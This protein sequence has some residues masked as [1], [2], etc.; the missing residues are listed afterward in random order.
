MKRLVILALALPLTACEAQS[1]ESQTVTHTHTV[2]VVAAPA[3]RA[4]TFVSRPK[5]V[6][7]VT[8]SQVDSFVQH[9]LARNGDQG[10]SDCYAWG[11]SWSCDM[12]VTTA[13]VGK[14]LQTWTI[15]VRNW[16]VTALK[17][18]ANQDA[19]TTQTTQAGCT[20]LSEAGNCYRAGEYCSDADHGM[21]GIDESG[22]AIVCEDVDGWRWDYPN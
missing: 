21:Q 11:T 4:R 18:K 17:V 7:H 3:K 14:Q 22:N 20:P 15:D 1:V 2:E 19:T 9:R 13:P 10:T 16:T 12:D 5:P 8:V 6:P